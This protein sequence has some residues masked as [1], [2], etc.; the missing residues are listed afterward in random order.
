M[1]KQLERFYKTNYLTLIKRVSHRAGGP[2]NAED[3]VQEAFVRALKYWG[4]FEPD[5]KE[6]GAWFHTILNN[7]LK[8][9]KRQELM[10]GMCLEFDEEL[11]TGK[12]M[13]HV[14]QDVL[15]KVAKLIEEK[16][17]GTSD[18]LSLYY[19]RGYKPREIAEIL[20]INNKAIRMA[21]WRFKD[22]MKE[23]LNV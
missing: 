2:Y 19:L 13:A 16:R 4:A 9:F 22:E 15:A 17:D 7:A 23:K 11:Y 1:N 18:I 3:V 12:E 5:K 14:D 21:V 20:D 8:D 6:L 10:Y